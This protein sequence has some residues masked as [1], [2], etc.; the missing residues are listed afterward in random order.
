[1]K[2][3][4]KKAHEM[5]RKM[6]ERYPEVDY[7][8]QFGLYVS[9]LLEKEREEGDMKNKM[10]N[11]NNYSGRIRLG[12][13]SLTTRG[14]LG[15]EKKVEGFSEIVRETEKAILFKFTGTI[16][17]FPG[18]EEEV[19]EE[20]EETVW[21]PKSQSEIGKEFLYFAGWLQK[22]NRILED[23]QIYSSLHDGE[24]IF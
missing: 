6:K 12:E 19:V 22:K 21:I 8:T 14:F 23:L 10:E 7:Q 20:V 5:T 17:H 15:Y 4:F 18:D 16:T 9:Y 13:T 1:M 11:K 24:E 3:L 2:N